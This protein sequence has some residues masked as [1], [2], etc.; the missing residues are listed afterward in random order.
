MNITNANIE[1]KDKIDTAIRSLS[2]CDL[3]AVNIQPE[4]D[5]LQRVAASINW[6]AIFKPWP[7]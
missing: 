5:N 3:Q 6:A 1:L 7:R 2:N 4:L